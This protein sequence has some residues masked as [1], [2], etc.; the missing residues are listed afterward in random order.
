[1]HHQDAR[2]R[3]CCAEASEDEEDAPGGMPQPFARLSRFGQLFTALDG[4]V[5][6]AS[7]DFI[8]VLPPPALDAM[9][10]E[11]TCRSSCMHSSANPGCT[12]QQEMAH[13]AQQQGAGLPHNASCCIWWPRRQSLRRI[14][15]GTAGSHR[16]HC[17]TAGQM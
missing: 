14:I 15:V 2:I 13:R 17:T 5:T 3:L 1:M 11:S 10:R 12:Q 6:R 7:L 8:Q 4:W 9:I 16:D